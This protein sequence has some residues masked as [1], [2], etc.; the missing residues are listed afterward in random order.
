MKSVR[1]IFS[2]ALAVAVV[3]LAGAARALPVERVVLKPSDSSVRGEGDLDGFVDPW[4]DWINSGGHNVGVPGATAL[5][6]N[7]LDFKDPFVDTNWADIDRVR[8]SM[9]S[10]GDEVAFILPTRPEPPSPTSSPGSRA[11][12]WTP[13]GT[14]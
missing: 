3:S 2:A 1:F 10:G 4:L 7:G 6:N 9:Y 11:G 14:T 5:T 8:V 13:A 12:S